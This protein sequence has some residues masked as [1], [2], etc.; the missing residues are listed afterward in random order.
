M[1]NNLDIAEK[2]MMHALGTLLNWCRPYDSA[3]DKM[4]RA[5][6][7]AAAKDAAPD[8]YD[9]TVDGIGNIWARFLGTTASVLVTCHTDTAH[10]N[11]SAATQLY[12]TDEGGVIHLTGGD[13]RGCLGAD[14]A[15]GIAVAIGLMAT[16]APYDFVFYVGE[17][18]GAVGSGWSVYNEPE[19]YDQYEAAIAFDR[20]GTTDIITHQ[21]GGRT[22]SD[23]FAKALADGLAACGLEGY[24][25]CSHGIFTDTEVL[26]PYVPECTN[27]SVGYKDEHTPS[28]T[29]DT[30]HLLALFRAVRALDLTRLPIVRE[31]GE[32]DNKGVWTS[33]GSIDP[34][35]DSILQHGMDAARDFVYNNPEAAAQLLCDLVEDYEWLQ[36]GSYDG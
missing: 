18:V 2:K 22:A 24:A 19:R 5:F 29:L 7:E 10:A 21:G 11:T 9:V 33:Y 36:G 34:V 1:T 17:E 3:G 15:A 8:W 12:A 23:K 27:V 6:I 16:A 31:P 20:R 35:V 13:Y 26:A 28:E 4:G 14:D 25:P 32:D 30:K